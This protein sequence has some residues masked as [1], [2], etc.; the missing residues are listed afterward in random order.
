MWAALAVVR[1]WS[2]G[3]SVGRLNVVFL[4]VG[5][6]RQ[7]P[8]GRV[9]HGVGHFGVPPFLGVGRDRLF[10]VGRASQGVGHLGVLVLLA[11]E[12]LLFGSR[13]R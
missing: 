11:S 2:L 6:N 10:P 12:A 7:F 1:S 3:K 9:S 8:L 5:R 13:S 4:G